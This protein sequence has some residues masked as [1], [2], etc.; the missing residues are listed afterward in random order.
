MLISNLLFLKHHF[1]RVSWKALPGWLVYYE[2]SAF[3]RRIHHPT[4]SLPELIFFYHQR[5]C[6]KAR[7]ASAILCISC[8]FFIIGP[9]LWKAASSSLESFSGM[10]VCLSLFSLHSVIIHFIDRKRRRLSFRGVGTCRRQ[11]T[12]YVF[13]TP[14][15]WAKET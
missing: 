7:L 12:K 9:W 8:F 5:K 2:M 1:Q 4:F 15:F 10:N 14:W 3:G 13:K 11:K 6:A